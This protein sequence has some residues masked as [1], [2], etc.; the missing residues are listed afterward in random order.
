MCEE[1]SAYNKKPVNL[2]SKQMDIELIK[3]ILQSTKKTRLQEIIPSTMGEPLLYENFDSLLELC[4]EFNFKLNLT[5]NGSFP[6]KNITEWAKVIIPI[7][8]D[9]KISWNGATKE[10]QESIMIGS[11]YEKGLEKIK[12]FLK[13]REQLF[14]ETQHYCQ[15]TLQ[16]TFM[17]KNLD[18]IPEVVRLGI[19]LGV[20]RIKGHHLW[21]HYEELKPLSLRRNK[22]AISR[23]NQVVKQSKEIA[24]HY[25]LPNGKKVLLEHFDTLTD[26][27]IDNL[28]PTG[29][30][31]FLGNEAWVAVDGQFSPCCAPEE[32]RRTLGDFGNLNH[33]TLLEIWHDSAYQSLCRNYL[34][35][36][37]CKSCNMRR[38]A[39]ELQEKFR[40]LDL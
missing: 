32:Q 12:T 11:C 30:C 10:V 25:L 3:K 19:Q 5:T 39:N 18:E 37:V 38:P 1:H 29:V 35:H 33:K 2:H 26:K 28:I 8:S 4:R 24:Q 17:E 23:W 6:K 31:P 40:R 14:Q 9:I 13:M 7:T 22:E 16:L 36:P 15:V 20:D 27:A 34:K 21:D